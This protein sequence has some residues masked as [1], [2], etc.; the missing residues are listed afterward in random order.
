LE[1]VGEPA[2]N[3]RRGSSMN[4]RRRSKTPLPTREQS[5]RQSDV[6]QSAWRHFREAA[7]MMA[8]LNT[9]VDAL[10]GQPLQLAIH[11]DEG[12]DRVETLLKQ[13]KLET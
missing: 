1:P 3:R 6:I 11:S 8:F 2:A 7:P 4:F 10:D 9:R 13:L 12:L 5:R